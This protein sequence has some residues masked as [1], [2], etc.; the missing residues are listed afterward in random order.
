MRPV[1]MFANAPL[2]VRLSSCG[3]AAGPVAAGGQGNDGAAVAARV[4]TSAAR[5]L[6]CH[7]PRCAAG[8]AGSTPRAWPGWPSA[9]CIV[10]SAPAAGGRYTSSDC[11]PHPRQ[12]AVPQPASTT[13]SA[14]ASPDRSA[15][16]AGPGDGGEY[17]EV[18]G[19]SMMESSR[20]THYTLCLMRKSRQAKLPAWLLWSHL[21]R[22]LA[23][24]RWARTRD[25]V[26]HD[27]HCTLNFIT[28]AMSTL[29]TLDPHI[30]HGCC[31][32]ET[33]PGLAQQTRAISSLT[34]CGGCKAS[35]A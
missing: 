2:R 26:L 25:T 12:P 6:A 11:R 15:C 30:R 32:R 19:P 20:R 31:Q 10:P 28:S 7:R 14:D 22:S 16:H 17:H 23:Q 4:I 1:R 3:R 24:A 35:S 18:C 27:A 33:T 9:A 29:F 13:R 8:S 21:G 5:L 34:G